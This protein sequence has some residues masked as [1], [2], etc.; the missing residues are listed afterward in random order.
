[1]EEKPRPKPTP[2]PKNKPDKEQSE[3]FI[4][5]ARAL[6]SDESGGAFERAANA[7][8][9]PLEHKVDRTRIVS[10]RTR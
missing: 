1:M 4:E 6:E 2:K 10:K 8:I 5:T 7:V 3:R 9:K